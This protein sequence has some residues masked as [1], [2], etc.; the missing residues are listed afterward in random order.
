LQKLKVPSAEESR[1]NSRSYS[2]KNMVFKEGRLVAKTVEVKK[3]LSN[4]KIEGN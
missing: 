1:M 2:L 3:T 4:K